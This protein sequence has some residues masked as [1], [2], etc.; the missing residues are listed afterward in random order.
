MEL[1]ILIFL[2]AIAAAVILLLPQRMEQQAKWVALAAAAAMF[3]LSIAMFFRFDP[4]AQGY[5]FVERHSWVD[6]GA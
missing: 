4:D 5:Q 3:A 2:P 6:I 1:S